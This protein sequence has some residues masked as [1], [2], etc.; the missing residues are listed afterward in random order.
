M[1]LGFFKILIATTNSNVFFNIQKQLKNKYQVIPSYEITDTLKRLFNDKISLL[2]LDNNTNTKIGNKTLY[3]F[4]YEINEL[5]KIPVIILDNSPL[6][7][8]FS[9]Y[10]YQSSYKIKDLDENIE[11]AILESD[12]FLKD[13]ED[14]QSFISSLILALESKDEYSRN[15]S[16]RVAKYAEQLAKDMN[17]SKEFVSLVH[18]A[19]LFH[20]IGKIGIPDTILLKPGS[21]TN[22][23]FDIIKTHPEKSENICAPIKIFSK[24]LPIVRAHHERYDGTGYPDKLKGENIPIESRIIAVA[25]A[26]D[27]LTSNRAYRNA[28]SMEKV[29]SIMNDNAGTQWDEDIIKVFLDNF[30]ESKIETLLRQTPT[31]NFSNKENLITGTIF[32]QK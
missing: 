32:S 11:S 17:Q 16:A 7:L 2:I 9:N 22:S 25:D 15:H 31:L 23:E 8:Q 3:S 24:L 14:I 28:F 30:E 29:L 10:G 26:F 21:L 19:G 12:N 6:G 20:D 4:L 27:A 5:K 18:M 1:N 13:N